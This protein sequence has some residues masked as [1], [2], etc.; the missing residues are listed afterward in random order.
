M[1]AIGSH[2]DKI[3]ADFVF[4]AAV[5]EANPLRLVILDIDIF[6]LRVDADIKIG[7][8]DDVSHAVER[9]EFGLDRAPPAL[10]RS[11]TGVS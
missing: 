5:D 4:L 3:G 2:N 11:A 10:I 7:M 6:H 9:G 1:N 8:I